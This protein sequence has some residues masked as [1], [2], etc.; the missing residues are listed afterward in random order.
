MRDAIETVLNDETLTTNE[1]RVNAI[2]AAMGQLTFPKDKFNALNSS[3]Q[4]L[5]SNY[6][7]LS[8]EYEQ[9]KLSKMTADEKMKAEQEKFEAD[10]KANAI[11]KSSLG[12]EKLLLKNGIEINDDDQ[13]LKDTLNSI[14]SEDYDKSIKL[15]N[16]FISLLNKT[17]DK[18]EKETTTKLLNDTPKPIGGTTSS[19]SVSKAEQ[20]NQEL[21]TAIENKDDNA[22]IRIYG[23]IAKLNQ[24]NKKM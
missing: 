4:E 19:P 23:E 12:V 15:A 1:E 5:K 11:E 17:K 7:S 14:I 8:N 13:E 6:S 22:Q 24:Q 18:T 20:L 10:K 2:T 3:Y 9:F 21:T 16:S